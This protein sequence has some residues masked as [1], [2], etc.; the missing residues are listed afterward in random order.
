[1]FR[2]FDYQADGET[3]F[4]HDRVNSKFDRAFSYDFAGRLT[5][6]LT[7]YEARGEQYGVQGPFKQIYQHDAWDNTTARNN[8]HWSNFFNYSAA[9]DAHN[10]EVNDPAWQYDAAGQMTQDDQYRQHKYD[11]ARRKVEVSNYEGAITQSFDGD[12]QRIK[13]IQTVTNPAS[14]EVT[15]YLRSSVLRGATVTE[16]YA[17]GNKKQTLVYAGS[18]VIARQQ[19]AAGP[20]IWGRISQTVAWQYSEPVTGSGRSDDGAETS[21]LD[22]VGVDAGLINPYIDP[23][24]DNDWPLMKHG[25]AGNPGS[26]CMLD[27]LPENC[28]MVELLVEA[29]RALRI[30]VLNP[31]APAPALGGAGGRTIFVHGDGTQLLASSSHQNPDGTYAASVTVG[32]VGG[33]FEFIPDGSSIG[34][35]PQDTSQQPGGAAC[36]RKLAGIFGGPGAVVGSTRDPLTVGRNPQVLAYDQKYGLPTDRIGERGLGHGPA[37]YDNP[38]PTSPDRGGIIHIFGNDNG[39]ATGTG[40]YT[41]AGGSAGTMFTRHAGTQNAYT[42]LN[43]NYNRGPYAGL[44]IAFVHVSA[45]SGRPNAM[46]S[47]RIGNIGG[48]GSID[49]PNYIHT[50]AVFYMNGARVDPRT[51]FCK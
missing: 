3:S 28:K 16:L 13:Q 14:S 21:E 31:F 44:T 26:G 20:N 43:V 45:G 30:N 51:I 5:Q 2:E 8:R 19:V 29:G 22:P 18:A 10:R 47:V 37:P 34:T 32:A 25:D 9:Y 33:H 1:M 46:G 40:L 4:V 48:L 17:T 12:G 35:Q 41:P 27:G 36:D 49:S 6:A 50:H 15:Y 23:N 39:T 24:Y 38:D 42:Q 11:A 7:G